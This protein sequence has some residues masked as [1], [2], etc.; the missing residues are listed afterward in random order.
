MCISHNDSGISGVYHQ[1]GG[2]GG[3]FYRLA[4]NFSTHELAATM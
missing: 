3:Y 4:E 1:W 2:G